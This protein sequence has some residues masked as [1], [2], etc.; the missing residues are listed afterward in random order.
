[1]KQKIPGVT[2]NRSRKDYIELE[3]KQSLKIG[4]ENSFSILTEGHTTGS[5]CYQAND[6]GIIHDY[7]KVVDFIKEMVGL[8]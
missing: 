2:N 4:N 8:V 7:L 1:L 3:D 6:I 5:M